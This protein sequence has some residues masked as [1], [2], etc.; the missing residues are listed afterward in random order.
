MVQ[1]SFGAGLIF[2]YD[3]MCQRLQSVKDFCKNLC[4]LSCQFYWSVVVTVALF[5]FSKNKG[6]IAAFTQN[7]TKWLI[8][9]YWL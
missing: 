1:R 6:M 3:K 7:M 4:R 2:L 5:S 8:S 9:Q